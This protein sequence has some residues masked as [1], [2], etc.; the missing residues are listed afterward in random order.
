M[1]L[2]DSKVTFVHSTCDLLII[3]LYL[4]PIS[5]YRPVKILY[6][7]NVFMVYEFVPMI[8]LLIIICTCMYDPTGLTYYMYQG[9]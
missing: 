2:K 3:T 6:L 9:K 7:V 4:G 5:L 8:K 1:L